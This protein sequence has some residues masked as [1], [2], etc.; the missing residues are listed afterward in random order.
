MRLSIL[1]FSSTPRQALA[2]GLAAERLGYHRY[3]IGEHHT[4]A[5]CANPLMVAA[6]LAGST[7]SIRVGTGATSVMLRNPYLVA[8]D[9]K[10]VCQLFGD[11]FDLGVAP[12]LAIAADV[13]RAIA[14]GRPCDLD[15]YAS[16][17]RTLYG[18]VTGRFSSA[19]PPMRIYPQLALP[20]WVLGTSDRTAELAGEL[21]VGFCTS[22]HHGSTK[23][24]VAEAIR[25][26]RSS[27]RPSPEFQRPYAIV[28]ISG[29][30]GKYEARGGTRPKKRPGSF[31][32][33]VEFSGRTGVCVDQI[34]ESAVE[35]KA[36]EAM[37]LSLIEQN[38]VRS[39]RAM[40]CDI[41]ETWGLVKRTA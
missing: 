23:K 21:G 9:A 22:F 31:S 11:R 8:E 36:D 3:W 4:R 7:E 32:R 2:L 17:V 34:R 16:R 10:L 28:V 29:I 41:A 30:C 6:F 33:Q 20:M 1:D 13:R 27:F 26:Y 40:F 12:S 38:I 25:V 19:D 39:N 5:Q 35:V 37:I 18:Y 15:G 24:G 14:D